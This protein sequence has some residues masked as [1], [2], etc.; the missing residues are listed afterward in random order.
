MCI[1]SC[2]SSPPPTR[3]SDPFGVP[4]ESAARAASAR[5]IVRVWDGGVFPFL[6]RASAALR[7]VAI[8]PNPPCARLQEPILNGYRAVSHEH[9]P[10]RHDVH[11]LERVATEHQ[12]VSIRTGL[13]AAL[14]LQLEDACRRRRDQRQ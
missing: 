12:D 13:E 14:A 3:I 11:R 1:S 10:L 4:V 2:R 8:E 9:V 6:W 5:L 7:F